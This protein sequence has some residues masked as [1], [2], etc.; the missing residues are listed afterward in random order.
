MRFEPGTTATLNATIVET[1]GDL[2]DPQNIAVN[3][4]D[5]AGEK[6]VDEDTPTRISTGFYEYEYDI[7]E[8]ASKGLWRIDWL[9]T[10]AGNVSALGMEYFEVYFASD[11][12]PGVVDPSI[13]S[14]IRSRLNEL[15]T[16]PLG[17]G[18]ETMF[19]DDQISD[20]YALAGEDLNKATYEA[21]KWKV[22]RYS[23]L[24]DISESGS[25][26]NLSQK[27]EQAKA[28]LDLWKGIV[29]E[30]D[31]AAAAAI[32]GR[33]VGRVINIRTGERETSNPYP[34]SGYADHIRLFPSHRLMIPAILG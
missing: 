10:L 34:F 16:D 6:V 21:W 13:N 12:A 32:M 1:D 3:I 27:F 4:Y 19:T 9:L 20:I 25:V 15:K 31:A 11:P 26:R 28:L 17:D 5:S 24:I 29:G 14:I 18:S 22:A 30:D 8:D 2:V 23:R 7:A 33:V